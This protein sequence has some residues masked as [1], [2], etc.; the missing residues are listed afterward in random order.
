MKPLPT[1]PFPFLM[2]RLPAA[3][4]LAAATLAPLAASASAWRRP[5]DGMPLP[6]R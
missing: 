4:P 3:L 5:V 2:Q 1:G 6:V